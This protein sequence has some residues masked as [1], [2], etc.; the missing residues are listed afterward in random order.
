MPCDSSL[1]SVLD[2]SD[3]CRTHGIQHHIEHIFKE[4]VCMGE[5]A[6]KPSPEPVQLVMKRIGATSAVFIG[7]TPDDV[8]A[9][10]A[11]GMWLI[12]LIGC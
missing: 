1:R 4:L 10:V 9:G 5:A 11:A 7:D 2:A 12:I 8:R 3:V 6:P